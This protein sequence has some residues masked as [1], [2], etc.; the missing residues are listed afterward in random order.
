MAVFASRVPR[1][2]LD[3]VDGGDHTL[4]PASLSEYDTTLPAELKLDMFV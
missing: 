1:V 3:V 2:F 4:L